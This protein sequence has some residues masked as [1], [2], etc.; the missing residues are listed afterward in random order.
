MVQ[1]QWE[2]PVWDPVE[3]KNGLPMLKGNN[4]QNGFYKQL[5]FTHEAQLNKGS[6]SYTCR[7]LPENAKNFNGEPP[8]E[9]SIRFA[10]KS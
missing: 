5:A 2:E 6:I 9:C 4:Q 3:E 10:T 8:K 1:L 7:I